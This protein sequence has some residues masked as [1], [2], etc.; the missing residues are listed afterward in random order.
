M[1]TISIA[2]DRTALLVMDFQADIVGRLGEAG[3][4]LVERTAL[5]VGAARAATPAIPVIHVVVGFRPGYPEVDP[6]HASFGTIAKTGRL[7]ID[8]G[9][10]AGSDIVAEVAPREGE[11]VVTK[12]RVGAFW[13]TDL[14]VLLRARRIDH[15]LLAGISTS[16][17]VLSTTRHAADADYRIAIV[18]DCCADPDE[19]V[20]RV[21]MDK[22]LP[23][24][25]QLVTAAD[26]RAALGA[27]RA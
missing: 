25:A 22:V 3:P 16:G 15:L 17:V 8:A 14:E 24:Q 10:P 19:E 5:V 4:A 2:A 20:H 23:R 21:L 6:H 11:P 27:A 13:G 18:R 7:V 12:R 1:S 9:H 26:V